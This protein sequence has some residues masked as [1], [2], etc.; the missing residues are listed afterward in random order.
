MPTPVSTRKKT[1]QNK[2][3]DPETCSEANPQ[4]PNKVQL[5][6]YGRKYK[7]NF[8]KRN[9]K[10]FTKI[11][12]TH[13][14]TSPNAYIY[15]H[16]K[17]Q[18]KVTSE[19]SLLT[20]CGIDRAKVKNLQYTYKYHSHS[21]NKFRNPKPNFN[22]LT[23]I[24]NALDEQCELHLLL[25]NIHHFSWS[26]WNIEDRSEQVRAKKNET[27]EYKYYSKKRER[28]RKEETKSGRKREKKREIEGW[29]NFSP[30]CN[31]TLNSQVVWSTFLFTRKQF[32]YRE[33]GCTLILPS[34]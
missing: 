21:W 3:W 12:T 2:K 11:F 29:K 6:P 33:E 13:I 9:K 18:G 24:S 4:S 15:I 23:Y 26:Y 28:E 25:H 14:E 16:I 1:K 32:L 10:L 34:Q 17:Y 22:N 7:A 27:H 30:D 31:W 19:N 20:L 5:I 8:F